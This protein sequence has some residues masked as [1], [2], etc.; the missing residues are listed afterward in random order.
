MIG[1]SN[2]IC[3]LAKARGET[4]RDS[5]LGKINCNCFG[6]GQLY[7]YHYEFVLQ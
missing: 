2:A 6:G 1:N 3:K 7:K 5:P 4:E